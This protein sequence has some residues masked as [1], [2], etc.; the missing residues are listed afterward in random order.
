[1]QP[2]QRIPITPLKEIPYQ[3]Y[4]LRKY[5]IQPQ[6]PYNED[7]SGSNI[8]KPE[9]PFIN[10]VY[11]IQNRIDKIRKENENQKS[12]RNILP[13]ENSF[14]YPENQGKY[15]K[16]SYSLLGN[17]KKHKN[18]LLLKNN[19]YDTPLNKHY[20]HYS[21]NYS[22]ERSIEDDIKYLKRSYN[23]IQYTLDR[24]MEELDLKQQLNFEFLKKQL[25]P[26][27][28]KKS[29]GDN[30]LSNYIN[31]LVT[32]KQNSFE[33]K[34]RSNMRLDNAI[35]RHLEENL[36]NKYNRSFKMKEKQNIE[37]NR[38][39][40][41]LNELINEYKNDVKQKKSI[42]LP[43]I[44]KKNYNNNILNERLKLDL[45]LSQQK[46]KNEDKTNEILDRIIEL[47]KENEIKKMKKKLMKNQI[48]MMQNQ[49]IQ[50]QM[51][52]NQMMENQMMDYNYYPEENIRYIRRRDYPLIRRRRRENEYE[53]EES[54]ESEYYKKQKAKKKKKK[55]KKKSKKKESESE[56]SE[57]ESEESEESEYHKKQK[58]KKKK[59]KNKKKSKNKESESETSESE[60]ESEESEEEK[61]KSE[62]NNK[63]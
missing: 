19:R 12:H 56:T 63:K 17:G 31:N 15:L 61:E 53:S 9:Y 58:V 42:S 14:Y 54:E 23:N 8:I 45:R 20:N 60:S 2:Y 59:K 1:M 4:I 40:N 48:L 27:S 57:S 34:I 47:Q 44:K 22:K 43:Y 16:K 7:N 25:K 10:K 52:E 6:K 36:L 30:D 50:N 3:P 41:I 35:N 21:N 13:L 5:N 29:I 24:K 49:M 51:M 32:Q 11:N 55:N 18:K 38:T 46:L 26:S 62:S 37:D 28:S 33:D 39:K